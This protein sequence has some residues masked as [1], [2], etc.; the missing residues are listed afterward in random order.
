M[1]STSFS[2][3]WW[4]RF[5]LESMVNENG[6]LSAGDFP[7]AAPWAPWEVELSAD[8]LLWRMPDDKPVE[9]RTVNPAG[10]L[11]FFLR[12]K[13]GPGVARFA[14]RFGVL[15]ICKHGRAEGAW[16]PPVHAKLA[17][18]SGM[19]WPERADGDRFREPVDGWLGYVRLARA[20]LS[21]SAVGITKAGEDWEALHN[22]AVKGLA[23]WRALS[24]D[25]RI[26]MAK[27]PAFVDANV[28]I[29][30]N[31]W[32]IMGQV[33]PILA[34]TGRQSSF[35]LEGSTF[36]TVGAQL[37]IAVSRAHDLAV[38]SGCGETYFRRGRRPQPGQRNFC[39]AC[40]DSGV[41]ARIRQRAR[42]AGENKPRKKGDADGTSAR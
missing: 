18:A 19:C 9:G 31:L 41:D 27:A 25:Q 26:T 21:L 1:I 40:K 16:L 13:D 30:V 8:S 4:H 17:G 35:Q 37:M 34:G 6:L 15:G 28:S 32:L 33:R 23:G 29:A 39:P 7:L 36:G 38:C 20:I 5:N 12:I 3:S 42:T 2:D 22:E 10:M 14:E 24:K 11:D